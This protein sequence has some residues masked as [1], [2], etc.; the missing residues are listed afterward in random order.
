MAAQGI[1]AM[2][3]AREDFVYFGGL[4]FAY[5]G[6]RYVPTFHPNQAIRFRS[7]E[8]MADQLV[9]LHLSGSGNE[10][11]EVPI[12]RTVGSTT[13]EGGILAV[14]PDA[15]AWN[16]NA[17]LGLKAEPEECRRTFYVLAN[18]L[19]QMTGDE[20]MPPESDFG[21]PSVPLPFGLRNVA[22]LFEQKIAEH[23]RGVRHSRARSSSGAVHAT[24]APSPR[25]ARTVTPRGS[26]TWCTQRGWTR[27]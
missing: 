18:V 11:R 5:G 27:L 17:H 21:D 13:V 7:L 19:S 10:A 22:T 23:M 9:H 26:A 4:E 12:P 8:F 6:L 3:G 24:Q 25:S 14:D 2:A 16:I 1:N 20:P 15:L